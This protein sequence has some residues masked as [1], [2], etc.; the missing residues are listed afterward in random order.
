MTVSRLIGPSARRSTPDPAP[1]EGLRLGA[2]TLPCGPAPKQTLCDDWLRRLPLIHSV[3]VR[4]RP[5][6]AAMERGAHWRAGAE[7]GHGAPG[8]WGTAGSG[9][10]R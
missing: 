10:G 7:N 2:P 4:G 8:L 5:R 3:L 1:P 9:V 6:V